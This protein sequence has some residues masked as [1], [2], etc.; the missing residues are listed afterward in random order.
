MASDEDKKLMN[1]DTQIFHELGKLGADQQSIIRETTGIRAD[2]KERTDAVLNKVADHLVDDTKR[3]DKVDVSMDK[4]SERIKALEY[5]RW[6]VLGI[7]G[8]VTALVGW[9]GGFFK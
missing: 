2:V 3:F 7:V 1:V 5:W 4:H 8:A 6:F 9:F